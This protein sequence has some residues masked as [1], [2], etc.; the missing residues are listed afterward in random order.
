MSTSTETTAEMT[1]PGDTTPAVTAESAAPELQASVPPAGAAQ[2]EPF[3]PER[4]ERRTLS[5][6]AVIGVMGGL[7]AALLGGMF[8][9]LVWQFGALNDS[10]D[11][12]GS[13]ID[14][15]GAELRAEM[16]TLRTELRSEIRAESSTLRAESG[17]LRAELQSEIGMLRAE[18][19]AGFR[20]INETLLD[21]TDRLARLEAAIANS[22]PSP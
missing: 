6:N 12:L 20:S 19:Q 5:P 13:R 10:I 1:A 17:T 21:H 9:L 15:Q 18:M 16:D 7:I 2:V 4:T 8:A 11:R 14:N 22:A 3:A